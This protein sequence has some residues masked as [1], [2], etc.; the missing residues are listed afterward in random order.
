MRDRDFNGFT[1]YIALIG[2][3]WTFYLAIESSPNG[4]KTESLRSI[5]LNWLEVF[6]YIVWWLLLLTFMKYSAQAFWELRS[7]REYILP[8]K[9]LLIFYGFFIF[10]VPI[11]QYLLQG[12]SSFF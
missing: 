2:A 10:G 3:I 9:Y 1:G 6:P 5:F 12:I 11:F 4:P 7:N 8:R